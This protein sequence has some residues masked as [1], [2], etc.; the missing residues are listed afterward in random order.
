[1]LCAYAR[2]AQVS[3]CAKGV[4]WFRRLEARANPGG[5]EASIAA[6]FRSAVADHFRGALKPPF[7][8]AARAAAGFSP[9]W[10][11][12]APPVAATC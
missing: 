8:E 5:C 7:N 6:A 1:M 2:L 3:H 10:Y 12:P 9:E 11:L 4:A